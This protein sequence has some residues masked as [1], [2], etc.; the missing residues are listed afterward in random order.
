MCS[1]L[2]FNYKIKDLNFINY[3]SQKRGPDLTN[4]EVFND[5]TFL[6]NLLSITGDLTKQP[7][8]QDN[9]V[10]LFNGE[11]Y[12]Y[13]KFNFECKSDGE[14]IIPLY[15]KYGPNFCTHLDGE[16]A[17][18]I[19]DFK[20]N[21]VIL[22][23]DTFATKPLWY[24][25]QDIKTGFA[26]YKSCLD[27]AGFKSPIKVQANTTLVLDL[28]SYEIE[29]EIENYSFDLNQF[30]TTYDDWMLAFSESIKK[31]TSNIREKIYIGLSSGY[32]SGAIACEMANQNINFKSFSI[33]AKEDESIIKQR[34]DLLSKNNLDTEMIFLSKKQYNLSK[35]NIKQTSEDFQYQ[36]PRLGK[37]TPNEMMSNDKGAIGLYYISKRAR[38]E[39]YKIYLSGQGADEIFSD[40]GFAGRRFYEHST[41]GG[42]F[43][44]NLETVFPWNSFYQGT[45]FSYLGK[46]ENIPGSLGIEGRY[47]FLDFS[48]VQEFL[49]LHPKLKNSNYKS[50]L[51][52]YLVMNRFPFKENEKVGFSCDYGLL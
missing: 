24:A 36:I 22:S 16:Y 28:K 37:I 35:S 51:R 18:V 14:V 17:I 40:Y 20:N 15:K 11:I 4:I 52:E 32:D 26:S 47:P 39:G 19:Y 3:F 7:F 6:H 34:H 12:N 50:V 1:F 9:I 45:Q 49:W 5:H 44:S 27:R 41:F 2:G 25:K 29:E 46:E 8:L 38:N 23:T 10:A 33:K 13:K 31:R 42:L 30:K 21:K 43:P 48:V